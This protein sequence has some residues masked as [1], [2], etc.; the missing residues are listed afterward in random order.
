MI[1][2]DVVGRLMRRHIR[3]MAGYAPVRGIAALSAAAGV[4]PERL[5][6]L[7]ANENPYGCSLR[8]RQAL[9][10]YGFYHVYPDTELAELA[11]RL[12][13]YAGV[14]PENVLPSA[15]SDELIDLMVRLFVEPGDRVV[16]AP[17]TF[18]MYRF[19]VESAGATVVEVPR[20]A[21][22]AI[23]VD[24]ILDAVAAGAKLVFL[25]SP[26]NPTGVAT[27]PTA[28]KA[29]LAAP[30]I[31][32]VDEAYYEFCGQTV[33]SWVM[34]Y[35]NLAVFRTFSK[36]AGLAG[37][38]AGYGL[39]PTAMIEHLQKIKIPYSVCAAAQIAM[40]ESL[41]DLD[42]L[43]GTVRAIVAERERLFGLLSA[44]DFL[45][46]LPSAANFI[47]CQ[48]A[49]GQ[50]RRFVTELAR[51]G[52]FVRYFDTPLLRDFIR[53]S[54]GRPEHSDALVAALKEIGGSR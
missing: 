16:L 43:R 7:D 38:R 11:G 33:A 3:D 27:P 29:L 9:G 24:G 13:T 50:G 10:A 30:A 54:V 22:Y 44:L 42:Y 8:V 15:G 37:L 19:C 23:D 17:P 32:V 28:I 52:I 5:I 49:L 21:D 6:K 1:D 2:T 4:P 40:T 25:D 34:E 20:R 41:A 39:F 53:I 35:P 48:L 36:W 26:N 47:L 12:A 46:P 45:R 14:R 18:G 51:R 31:V